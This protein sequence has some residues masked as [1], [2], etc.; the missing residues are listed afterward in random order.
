MNEIVKKDT[1]TPDA[2]AEKG[3]RAILEGNSIREA[4]KAQGIGKTKLLNH[5]LKTKEGERRYALAMVGK[6]ALLA[7]EIVDVARKLP[8][9]PTQGQLGKAKILT[10]ALKWTATKYWQHLNP[11]LQA[12]VNV[13]IGA[14]ASTSRGAMVINLVNG[15]SDALEPQ[16]GKTIDL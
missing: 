5:M 10:E 7:D 2:I 9:D 14:N 15:N 16:E 12:G 4:A 8:D 6:G 11:E 3:I 1:E 13:N